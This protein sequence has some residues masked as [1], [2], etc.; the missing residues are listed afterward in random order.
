[1]KFFKLNSSLLLVI[2]LLS[3]LSVNSGCNYF[4]E[5]VEGNGVVVSDD[6]P[7]KPFS[8]IQIGGAFEVIL[9]QGDKVS[10][11][12]EAD[13]NLLDYIITEVRGGKL[14]IE[15]ESEI[16]RCKELKAYITFVELESLELSGAV[17]IKGEGRLDFN[18]LNIDASGATEINMDI[19]AGILKM[20][21]SGASEV[22]L[23]GDADE[24]Y[25]E[26]SGASELSTHDLETKTFFLD[27]SGAGEATIY[28][29]EKL[30]V[31]VSGAAHVAYSG[32]PEF[33]NQDVSGAASIKSR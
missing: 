2:L 7:V 29:T 31:T 3:F 6:R 24:V 21:I 20:D 28:V 18:K 17:E 23:S 26:A 15:T 22:S 30:D 32:N 9:T 11:K 19:T 12:I 27:I 13:E 16:R 1:M 25:I 5:G 8:A 10:L 33:V 14:I 4:F